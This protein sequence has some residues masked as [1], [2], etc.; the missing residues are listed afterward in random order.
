MRAREA[1]GI[2]ALLML[3]AGQGDAA[4]GIDETYTRPG[5]SIWSSEYYERM[6]GRNAFGKSVAVVVGVGDYDRFRKLSAP[7][8][9]AMRVRDFLR[10]EAGFDQIITL[11]DEKATYAR[12]AEL[13]ETRIPDA[14]G[15]NDRFLFYFSGHGVTRQLSRTKRGYLILKNS[16]P[17]SWQDM[18]DMERM[19]QWTENIAQ[20]RHALFLLD[21]CFSGLAAFEAKVGDVQA[22]TLARLMQPGH[23]IVTAGTEGEETFIYKQESLFTQAFLSA[24]R[25]EGMTP[26]D[27]I[28]SLNEM[29]ARVNRI[30]DARQ[31]EIGDKIRMTP[32]HYHSRVTNNAGEFFFL[33]Q[34]RT[35]AT[36]NPAPPLGQPVPKGPNSDMASLPDPQPGGFPAGSSGLPTRAFTIRSRMEATGSPLREASIVPTVEACERIC[37]Q[38]AGC[39]A[40]SFT[41]LT[42][43]CYAYARAELV[44]NVF[45]DSGFRDASAVVEDRTAVA[46]TGG[47]AGNGIGSAPAIDS[48]TATS[49][50]A[51]EIRTGMEAS[52]KEADETSEV[53]SIGHCERKCAQLGNCQVFTY[54]QNSGACYVYSRAELSPNPHFN[55]GVRDTRP[56]ER[57]VVSP[58]ANRLF[59]VRRGTEAMGKQLGQESFV[60]SL[61]ECEQ[62]CARQTDCRAYTYSGD[63]RACYAYSAAQLVPNPHFESGIRD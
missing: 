24:A 2:V 31:A 43:A 3:A 33:P 12:I 53:A 20:A 14:V 63:S 32:R 48:P 6:I 47:S 61:G 21:A 11:T 42:G 49:H 34:A 1:L 40:F 25:G 15:P 58:T 13:M 57:Q 55:S 54:S 27:G 19:R 62:L 60:R 51:F 41:S 39:N 26:Q 35:L 18:I 29:M 17:G 22:R 16:G 30:L 38:T 50:A 46:I 23:H 5:P 37:T 9:D 28:V 45:Y 4:A 59:T 36:P 8:G 44:P 52:G 7:A 10:D 56:R